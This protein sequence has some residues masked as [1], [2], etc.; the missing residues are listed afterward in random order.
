M[1]SEAELKQIMSL[2][3]LTSLEGKDTVDDIQTLCEKAMA[4][5]VAAVCVF[6]TLVKAAKGF[7]SGSGIKVAS[8]AGGF[9]AGQIPLE[10]KENEVKYALDQGADEIDMVINRG[11]FL[12]RNYNDTADEITALKSLCGKRTLKVILETGELGAVANIS[13]ASA[14]A[15]KAG[16]DFIKT[17][18]GK[19]S[20]GATPESVRTMLQ[21]IK[22]Y[23]DASGRKVGI[24]PAGGIPDGKTAALYYNMTKEIVGPD[25]LQPSLLRFGASRL[26]DS[27]LSEMKGEKKDGQTTGY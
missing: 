21:E 2:I 10:L 25:W 24:K 27:L 12:S 6:P 23:F 8:V 22:I 4:N 14:L 11:R 17:S 1:A 19:I 9:P 18:T 20:V 16:A 3:D 7:L 13:R 15:M 26:V 5:G